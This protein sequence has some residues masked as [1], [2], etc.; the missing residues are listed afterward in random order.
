MGYLYLFDVHTTKPLYRARV[1][2]ETVFVTCNQPSTGAIF[3]IT[4]RTGQV[5]RFQLN[6]QAIVPYIISTLRDNDLGIKL[7]G[8]LGL[9]GAENLYA[10][11]FERLISQRLIADAARLVANSGGALRSPATIHR[12][13]QILT[14]PGI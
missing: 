6:G 13:Q 1:T 4:V 5:L 11:E 2:Q 7:A 12:F 8:R 9:P 3:G 10:A 14:E